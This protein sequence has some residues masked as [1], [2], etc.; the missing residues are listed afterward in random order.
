MWETVFFNVGNCPLDPLDCCVPSVRL[1][2]ASQIPKACAGRK[3][4]LITGSNVFLGAGRGKL[5][6]TGC[7]FYLQSVE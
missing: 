5:G 1:E 7:W 6:L 4:K 2:P 3:A